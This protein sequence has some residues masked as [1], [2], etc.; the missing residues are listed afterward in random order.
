MKKLLLCPPTFYDIRYEINPWMDVA[1]PVDKALATEQ[2]NTLTYAYKQLG[3]EYDELTPHEDLPDQIYTTDLGHAE[4]NT[5]VKA[6]FKYPERQ[7]EADI[8][9]EY[10]RAKGFDIKTFG[11][12]IFFEG[13]DFLKCGNKYFFG[14]GKR[15]SKEALP[16]L[17]EMLDANVIGINL[18]D[19]RFYH[20][21]TC[22]T[23]LSEQ[24]ALVNK[25]ALATEDLETLG[26]HFDRLIPTS[27]ADNQMLVCNMLVHEKDLIMGEGVSNE[28]K[29]ELISLGFRI[30]TVPMSEYLKGGGN[31]HCVSMEVFE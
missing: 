26:K 3:I 29:D 17:E 24:I 19:E 6:S 28:L 30:I 2:Y 5:F 8:A 18:P 25:E 9:E 31:V 1:N 21:D 16:I 22:F 7:K 11:P 14:H 23:P 20:L 12:E 27:H 13:G 10:F 4:G 15:S